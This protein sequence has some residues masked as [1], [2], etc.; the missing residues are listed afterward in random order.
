M[1]DILNAPAVWSNSAGDWLYR[2][3]GKDA[4]TVLLFGVLLGAVVSG[5]LGRSWFACVSAAASFG[6]NLYFFFWFVRRKIHMPSACKSAVF[7]LMLVLVSDG[8][9]SAGPALTFLSYF[10]QYG[11]ISAVI[12]AETGK[13]G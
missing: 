7:C 11:F 13:D 10:I 3:F 12:R 2:V 1:K 6:L 8:L 9:R 5:C 4:G